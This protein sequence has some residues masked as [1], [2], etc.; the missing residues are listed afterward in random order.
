MKKWRRGVLT[1]L[2]LTLTLALCIAPAQAGTV[3]FMAVNDVPLE[4]SASNMPFVSGG[5]LYVPYTMFST[6]YTGV[7]LGVYAVYNSSKGRAMVYSNR[8]QLIFDLQENQ[9]YDMDGNTYTERAMRRNSTVYL[10]IARVCAVFSDLIR[11]SRCST[12]YGQL[13]RLKNDSVVLGDEAFVAAAD[14]TM[15][16]SLERYLQSLP[17]RQ[18]APSPNQNASARP[19]PTPSESPKPAGGGAGVFLA[20]TLTGT[21]ADWQ[22]GLE[23]SLTALAAQNQ[24]GL[25]FLTPEQL[26]LQ[27][28]L[29]RRLLGLGHLVGVEIAAE[30]HAEALEEWTQAKSTLRN[31]ARCQPV[32]AWCPGLDENGLEWLEQA[33]CVCWHGGV[34][35]RNLRGSTAN[36]V[37]VLLRQ[38]TVGE[39]AKNFVL[40]DASAGGSLAAMLSGLVDAEF[41]LHVPVPTELRHSL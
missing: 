22:E 1:A 36:R 16:Q 7:T 35:A 18:P 23:L 39:Q 20:F 5:I 33:G 37:S 41:Q 25:F 34:D 40:L 14:N 2:A 31:T 15:S 30:K 24:V 8:K 27:D 10:P 11:Y 28:N 19:S 3:Y 29:V 13:V 26:E 12:P 32:A 21:E 38:L 9:T 6:N 4:L 17:S